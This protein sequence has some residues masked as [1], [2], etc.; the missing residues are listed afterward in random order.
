MAVPIL[1]MRINLVSVFGNILD[2]RIKLPEC[3]YKI[4]LF[5]SVCYNIFG[6]NRFLRICRFGEFLLCYLF[7]ISFR[8][9]N[10]YNLAS[11]LE[12]LIKIRIEYT[13]SCMYYIYNGELFELKDFAIHCVFFTDYDKPIVEIP[14]FFRIFGYC[15]FQSMIDIFISN[16][17]AQIQAK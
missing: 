6:F 10:L 1:E 2:R 3:T 17:I 4:C 11:E 13:I 15:F 12:I 14:E 9:W 5:S 8:S 7:Y 16:V